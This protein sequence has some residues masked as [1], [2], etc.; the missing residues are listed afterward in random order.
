LNLSGK[1]NLSMKGEIFPAGEGV[2]LGVWKATE[3]GLERLSRKKDSWQPRYST[4]D[5]I[6]IEEEKN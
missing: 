6:I 4:H 2:P 5:A 1:K 3:R